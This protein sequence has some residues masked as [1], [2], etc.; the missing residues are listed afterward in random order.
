LGFG[1]FSEAARR[2]SRFL[3]IPADVAESMAFEGGPVPE[4]IIRGP[5]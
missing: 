4:E 5:S 1:W 2:A 3:V